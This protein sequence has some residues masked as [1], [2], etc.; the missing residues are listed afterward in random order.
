MA[1]TALEGAIE[2]HCRNLTRA[3]RAPEGVFRPYTWDFRPFFAWAAHVSPL[4]MSVLSTVV[5][6]ADAAS[7][8]GLHPG[9]AGAPLRADP[10]LR[11]GLLPK[12]WLGPAAQ[13]FYREYHAALAPR[14]RAFL[15]SAFDRAEAALGP[16]NEG[17]TP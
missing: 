1:S 3:G 15:G 10:G 4:E 16:G 13:A 7:L 5:N 8:G 14:A 12:G 6:E 9:R 17:G 2:R 11:P